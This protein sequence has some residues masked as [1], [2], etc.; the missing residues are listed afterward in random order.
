M[1]IDIMSRNYWI[2]LVG[3]GLLVLAIFIFRPVPIPKESDCEV[4]K[5]NVIQIDEQGVKD[6]VFTIAGQKR[7]FYVNRGLERG[8]EL[9]KL[10]SE[11]INK[12]VTIKYPRYWT[13]LG[14]SSKHIA[15]IEVS[16]RTI[17]TEID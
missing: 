8:L 14:N 12:E 7:T 3:V 5:G 9:N 13:L 11:L 4:V 16:G 10:R 15:K 1:T 2:S 17:F 6:I